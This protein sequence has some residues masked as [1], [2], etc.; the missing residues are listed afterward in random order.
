MNILYQC[1][2]KL[3]FLLLNESEEEEKEYMI[4]TEINVR[5]E[6]NDYLLGIV[7][8]AGSTEVHGGNDLIGYYQSAIAIHVWP[9]LLCSRIVS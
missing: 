8:L 6:Y 1:I 2:N 9:T 5:R 3:V 7:S 4:F